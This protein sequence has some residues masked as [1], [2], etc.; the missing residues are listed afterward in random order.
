M[1]TALKKLQTVPYGTPEHA[2]QLK[3]V[4]SEL[5]FKEYVLCMRGRYDQ[6]RMTEADIDLV[7]DSNVSHVFPNTQTAF[8][9]PNFYFVHRSLAEY[10]TA[11]RQINVGTLIYD[12][13]G[14]VVVIEKL[15]NKQR[16]LVGGHVEY[17][18]SCYNIS[19]RDLCYKHMIKEFREEVITDFDYQAL[20]YYP[21]FMIN[22]VQTFW[23]LHHSWFV[24]TREVDDLNAFK[25]T[26]GEPKKIDIK[27]KNI[28]DLLTGKNTKHSLKCALRLL[29]AHIKSNGKT[30]NTFIQV[31]APNR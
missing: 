8:E 16:A 17:D 22:D 19:L 29:K 25:F 18:P 21:E 6:Q 9:N 10:N 4:Q 27:V 11:H 5:S 7:T 2:K 23:D 1:S 14:N 30:D 28:D 31:S 24:Y 26:S 13:N 3:K 15:S 20:P 12:R